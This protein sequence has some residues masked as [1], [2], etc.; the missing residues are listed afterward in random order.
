M[1]TELKDFSNEELSVLRSK[2]VLLHFIHSF[3]HSFIHLFV[4]CTQDCCS[5]ARSTS[6]TITR[7]L[8][9]R[10]DALRVD[11]LPLDHR[12]AMLTWKV[13]DLT[14]TEQNL[15]QQQ[16][17][18][19]AVKSVPRRPLQYPR[20]VNVGRRQYICKSSWYTVDVTNNCC[21]LTITALSCRH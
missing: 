21:E 3:I 18:Q 6:V 19:R 2:S 14:T 8:R 11:N 12:P 20:D 4:N 10:P 5:D 1:L 9:A 15:A 7:L 13:I 16:Q 17:Q